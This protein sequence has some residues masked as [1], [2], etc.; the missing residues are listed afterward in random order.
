MLVY[1]FWSSY[2]GYMGCKE[3]LTLFCTHNQVTTFIICIFIL[4]F[5]CT[6][7]GKANNVSPR[8]CLDFAPKIG[9]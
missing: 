1:A 9:T 2:F 6:D 4:V 8:P 7:G 5:Y 3:S